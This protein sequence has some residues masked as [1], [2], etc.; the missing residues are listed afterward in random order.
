MIILIKKAAYSWFFL[1]LICGCSKDKP[2]KELPILSEAIL[3]VNE[4]LVSVMSRADSLLVKS[5]ESYVAQSEDG[6]Y[7]PKD[8]WFYVDSLSV[9]PYF[10]LL[11]NL[12]ESNKL[13]VLA[14]TSQGEYKLIKLAFLN[15]TN[16]ETIIN[17]PSIPS[18]QMGYIL[19]NYYDTFSRVKPQ[20]F[21][22]IRYFNHSE[23]PIDAEEVKEMLDFN[24]QLSDFFKIPEL[25]FD[26]YLFDNSRELFAALGYEYGPDMHSRY[27]SNSFCRP[28]DLSIFSGNSTA[29]HPHELAHLYIHTL[30][31]NGNAH[32]GNPNRLLDEGFATYFGG[33]QNFTLRQ[34]T[35]IAQDYLQSHQVCF[36]NIDQL[37]F[38]INDIV[39]FNNVFF[40]NFVK[41]LI[42]Y[43][44]P[45]YALEILSKYKT[46]EELDLLIN[47]NMLPKETFNEFVIRIILSNNLSE[48]DFD[49]E[50]LVFQNVIK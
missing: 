10:E 32:D 13:Q 1:I 49:K 9:Y 37:G 42:E 48:Y 24:K 35:Q 46:E 19:L 45:E 43:Y 18:K 27:Q 29:Y 50:Q 8:A 34:S 41:Y 7:N 44:S 20:Q 11:K 33:S 39:N 38:M 36:D 40:G 30:V 25:Q 6:Y 21:D 22:Y 3:E 4:S 5:V 12:R 17:I 47:L 16:I 23:D 26:Y 15:G 14:L 31:G 28:A 2:E